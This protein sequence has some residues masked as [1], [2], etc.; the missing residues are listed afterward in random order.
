MRVFIQDVKKFPAFGFGVLPI[1][2]G[3][4]P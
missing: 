3:K 2:R 1:S 4:I